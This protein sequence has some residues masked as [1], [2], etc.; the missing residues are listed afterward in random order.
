MAGLDATCLA[1]IHEREVAVLG[2]DGVSDV[3]PSRVANVP[4]PIH[5]VALVAMGVHLLDNLDL[6]ELAR[7]CSTASRWTFL[8]MVAPLVLNRGTA[9]P[10]NPIAVF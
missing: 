5:S 7:S 1:W 4:L 10:V 9:S 2:S 6:D 8:F 3:M